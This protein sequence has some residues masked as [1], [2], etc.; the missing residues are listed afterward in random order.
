[1]ILSGRRKNVYQPTIECYPGH[2]AIKR[3]L[4]GSLFLIT[5]EQSASFKESEVSV[6]ES[7]QISHFNFYMDSSCHFSQLFLLWYS[8]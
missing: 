8:L 6:V 7:I 2:S 1:M 3:H 5:P 4:V